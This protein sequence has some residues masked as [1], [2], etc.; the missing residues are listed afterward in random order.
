M[1]NTALT[2]LWLTLLA[3]AAC[4]RE[5]AKLEGLSHEVTVVSDKELLQKAEAAAGEVIRNATDCA[6]VVEAAP[7]AQAA[8][9]EA[10]AHVQSIAGRATVDSLKHQVAAI[11][12][13]CPAGGQN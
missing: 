9:D 5:P 3:T 1:R 12:Q 10:T 6:K 13:A 4:Q 11:V 2:G 8:L 7:D